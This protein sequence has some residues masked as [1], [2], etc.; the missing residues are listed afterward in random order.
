MYSLMS[1][2]I[3]ADGS[4]NRNFA[5]ARATSV[6]PTPVGPEKMNEPMGR[7][8]SLSPARLRRIE[9]DRALMASSCAT[10]DTWSSSSMRSSLAV[11]AS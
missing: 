10:T 3:S 5:R 2:R 4:A 6:L 1:T 9:R 8:G 7:F 11:S